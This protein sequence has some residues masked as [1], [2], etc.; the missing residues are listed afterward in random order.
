[1]R[2]RWRGNEL[3][4]EPEASGECGWL[5]R[6][7]RPQERQARQRRG[8]WQS[9]VPAQQPLGLDSD[10][11]GGHVGVREVPALQAP[12]A[13]TL[14]CRCAITPSPRAPRVAAMSK[15]PCPASRQ[16]RLHQEP[17][18]LGPG[19]SRRGDDTTNPA[20]RMGF[21]LWPAGNAWEGNPLTNP[22]TP[23]PGLRGQ[24]LWSRTLRLRH[25][26]MRRCLLGQVRRSG[27]A[28]RRYIVWRHEQAGARW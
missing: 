16:S 12:H 26:R 3:E 18:H 15:S 2:S 17:G 1:M 21:P 22:G 13:K 6:A 24:D 19:A 20:A 8:W 11:K 25:L 10:R 4:Q 9:V 27:H 7:P 28:S 14:P 23:P 5:H